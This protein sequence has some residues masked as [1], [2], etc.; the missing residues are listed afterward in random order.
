MKYYIQIFTLIL[1]FSSCTGS[2]DSIEESV[3]VTEACLLKTVIESTPS[4][5]DESI[6]RTFNYNDQNRVESV[7]MD[8]YFDHF[9]NGVASVQFLFD[10]SGDKISKM[11]FEIEGRTDVTTFEYENG[12]L[13]K[14]IHEHTYDELTYNANG[15]LTT[16]STHSNGEIILQFNLEYDQD[17]I[18]SIEQIT[19]GVDK[20]RTVFSNHS[21]DKHFAENLDEVIKLYVFG[22]YY[23]DFAIRSSNMHTTEEFYFLTDINEDYGQSISH[24]FE[25]TTN[26]AGYPTFR[27]SLGT[28]KRAPYDMA[29]T[30]TNCD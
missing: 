5:P 20:A 14:A 17:N 26:S 11:E 16:L 3:I 28:D 22:Y 25:L 1:L 9:E 29:L 15:Q 23:G 2:D 6:E 21:T 10:Y 12:L 19:P 18:S 24:G 27:K 30:Y 7:V 4:E 13:V 8:F